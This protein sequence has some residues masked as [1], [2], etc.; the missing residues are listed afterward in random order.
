[1]DSL[2]KKIQGMQPLEIKDVPVTSRL[3]AR[4]YIQN[5]RNY[6]VL[7]FEQSRDPYYGTPKWNEACLKANKIGEITDTPSH[8]TLSSRLFL[9]K[10]GAP[11]FCFE[12]ASVV[13]GQQVLVYCEGDKVVRDLKFRTSDELE[14][15]KYNICN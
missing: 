10:Q 5:Q 15:K 6:L 9:D 11:G 3:E 8:I 4:K 7:L 12:D 14:I 2:D 13:Y 1:M